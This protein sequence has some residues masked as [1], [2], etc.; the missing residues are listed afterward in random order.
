ML[1]LLSNNAFNSFAPLVAF[2]ISIANE[3]TTP[4]DCDP[5]TNAEK[6]MKN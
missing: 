6:Q 5:E 3:N 2:D 4:T 1:G